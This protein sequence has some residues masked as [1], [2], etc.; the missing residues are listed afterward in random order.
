MRLDTYLQGIIEKQRGV[1]ISRSYV[2]RLLESGSVT[3]LNEV[4]KKKGFSF[5]PAKQVPVIDEKKLDNLL[6]IYKTGKRSDEEADAW[7]ASEMGIELDES[8]VTRA[9]DIKPT[10]V[11]ETADV[12]VVNKPPGVSS[13]PGKGDRGADSMVYRFI[14]YMRE[15][16]RYIPRAGLLHRLDKDTQGLLLFAK[17]M[18]TY[19][20]IKGQ[21]EQ[22]QVQKY[23]L[24]RCV[25]GPFMHNQLKGSVAAYR[26][27]G[28]GVKAFVD[29][30]STQEG[31]TQI[32]SNQRPVVLD[33]YIGRRK[34]TPYMVYTHDTKVAEELVGS[35]PCKSD[36]YVASIDTADTL[37]L[38]FVP[39]TG[40]THQIRA[41][42]RY[43]GCSVQND[44]LY[45]DKNTL[46]G[47]LQL[48]A[49]G[50]TLQVKGETVS[51]ELPI[52]KILV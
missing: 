46:G 24:A 14:K 38:L 33:G 9:G 2:E 40:R 49:I 47:T 26:S 12:L 11:L 23:Y 22:R 25:P 10:I 7:D 29:Y 17:N 50:V 5:D 31:I 13:H 28:R 18:Q 1:S 20:E 36:V 19:N 16:H 15:A 39:H 44:R 35:K 48:Y 27:K 45:G 4:I 37:E 34:G 42:A 51:I 21:F 32:I 8:R 43:L 52:K 6:S 3:F 30:E 41:Q